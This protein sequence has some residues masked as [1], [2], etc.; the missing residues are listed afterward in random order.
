[1]NKS[2]GRSSYINKSKG[3]ASLLDNGEISRKLMSF[4]HEKSISLGHEF[5]MYCKDDWT[6]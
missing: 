5:Q 1:M 4:C 2:I 3:Q 6:I